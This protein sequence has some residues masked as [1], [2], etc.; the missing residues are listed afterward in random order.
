MGVSSRASDITSR[1]LSRSTVRARASVSWRATSI[2]P[3]R[4]S[5]VLPMRVAGTPATISTSAE[6]PGA[7]KRAICVTTV[8][9]SRVTGTFIHVA[10]AV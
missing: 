8:S 2:V 3:R 1:E 9:M 7:R 4:R 6:S 5:S 10:G